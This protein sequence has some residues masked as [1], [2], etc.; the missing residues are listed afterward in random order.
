VVVAVI[1][2]VMFYSLYNTWFGWPLLNFTFPLLAIIE[3]S[4]IQ[5]GVL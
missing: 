1:L 2:I 4:A 3:Y 5:G